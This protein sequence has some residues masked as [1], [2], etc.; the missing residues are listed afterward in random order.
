MAIARPVVIIEYVS[1]TVI[2]AVD[3][4]VDSEGLVLAFVCILVVALFSLVYCDTTKF[5]FRFGQTLSGDYVKY[6]ARPRHGVAIGAI[7]VAPFSIVAILPCQG[8]LIVDHVMRE[9]LKARAPA[10][11]ADVESRTIIAISVSQRPSSPGRDNARNFGAYIDATRG[12]RNDVTVRI[13]A[14]KLMT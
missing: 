3:I 9:R 12:R 14:R 1:G 2:A 4:P 8:S 13:S 5:V 7:F 11:L 10:I 6:L